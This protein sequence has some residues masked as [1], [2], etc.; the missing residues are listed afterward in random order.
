[1]KEEEL[2]RIVLGYLRKKGYFV[3]E[4]AFC[5]ESGMPADGLV[6][7]LDAEQG[8]L[9][10]ILFFTVADGQFMTDIRGLIYPGLNILSVQCV[11]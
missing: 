5:Q 1:M 2:D 6:H 9:N 11:I 7:Q 3:A 4:Q 8:V 10:S